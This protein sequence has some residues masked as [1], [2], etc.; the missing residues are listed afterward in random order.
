YDLG[1]TDM[2]CFFYD[3]EHPEKYAIGDIRVRKALAIAFNRQEMADTLFAGYAKPDGLYYA[4]PSTL[5]PY[6]DVVKPDSFDPEG[7][8]KLLAEAGYASGFSLKLWDAD[9]GGILSK[10]VLAE[11]GYWRKV[12]VDGQITPIAWATL[13]GM[14]VPKQVSE[15]WNSMYT[16]QVPGAIAFEKMVTAYHGTKGGAKN[17]TNKKLDQ[18]IELAPQTKDPKERT[19]IMLDAAVLAHDEYACPGLLD[20]LSPIAIGSKIGSFTPIP[21]LD[22]WGIALQSMAHGK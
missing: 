8:K 7:S 6:T 15:I 3:V 11:S 14:F 12:G 10:V 9:P 21:G 1:A 19:K 4:R 22:G 16:W 5:F 20:A 13:R 17:H 2:G 18:L